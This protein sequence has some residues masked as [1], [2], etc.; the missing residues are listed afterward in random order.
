MPYHASSLSAVIIQSTIECNQALLRD[1]IFDKESELLF[2]ILGALALCFGQTVSLK[3]S[4][5]V[6]RNEET[7]V[8]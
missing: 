3:V 2:S 8:A 1:Y 7:D 6:K 5:K 4:L